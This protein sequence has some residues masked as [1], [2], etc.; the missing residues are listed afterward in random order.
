MDKDSTYYII[1]LTLL[2]IGTIV[3]KSPYD[4]ILYVI[5][6]LFFI[7]S[8]ILTIKEYKNLK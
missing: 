5:A 6:L 4:L 2:C 3:G 8:I 7:I 1:G